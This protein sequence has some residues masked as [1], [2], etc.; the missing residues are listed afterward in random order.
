MQCAHLTFFQ[1]KKKGL[2]PSDGGSVYELKN[3]AVKVY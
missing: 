3:A 1:T 2:L